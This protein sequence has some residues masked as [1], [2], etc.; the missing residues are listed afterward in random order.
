MLWLKE[1]TFSQCRCKDIIPKAEWAIHKATN[2]FN[3][4][5]SDYTSD[6]SS[7][8]SLATTKPLKVITEKKTG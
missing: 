1:R 3:Q 7:I 8:S 6:T 4:K 2:I 5:K